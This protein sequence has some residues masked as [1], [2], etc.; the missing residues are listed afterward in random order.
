MDIMTDLSMKI[1]EA[2]VPDEIDLA[3]LMTE[4]FIQGG[5]ERQSLFIKQESSGLGA[6]GLTEG[7]FL[8]PWILKGISIT[9]HL[10]PQFLSIDDLY[11]EE[12]YHFLGIG[13]LLGIFGKSETKEKTDQLPEEY[14]K[15]LK[16]LFNTFSSE[17]EAAGLP[18]EQ[19]DRIIANV[20]VTLRKNPSVSL[21]FVERV[22]ASK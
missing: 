9:A 11:L 17:L 3:P 5:K 22:A 19:C 4:A 15:P 10:I 13:H 18:E 21:E 20:L 16:S 7:I 12:V 8:F 2:A 1:A 14:E 6:F